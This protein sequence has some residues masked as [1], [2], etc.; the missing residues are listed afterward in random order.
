[1]FELLKTMVPELHDSAGVSGQDIVCVTERD[2]PLAPWERTDIYILGTE[3][4]AVEVA[5]YLA[6]LGDS[7][8][9]F[10]LARSRDR[11]S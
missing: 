5:D 8:D 11:V 4:Q 6:S 9:S 2:T 10:W 7:G 1:M 3:E